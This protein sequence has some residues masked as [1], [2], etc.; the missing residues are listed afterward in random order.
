MGWLIYGDFKAGFELGPWWQ[1]L[2]NGYSITTWIVVFNLGSTGLL[3]SWLMKYSDN[4]VKVRSL[5]I[6]FP[7]QWIMIIFLVEPLL[8]NVFVFC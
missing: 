4:I 8:N 1:R 6:C 2:F 5:W 7:L 3:V